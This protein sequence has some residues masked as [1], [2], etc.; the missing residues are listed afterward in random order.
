MVDYA[1]LLHN[2]DAVVP[3]AADKNLPCASRATLD[4]RA[5]VYFNPGLVAHGEV[6]YTASWR[7]DGRGWVPP[8]RVEFR[9]TAEI[10]VRYEPWVYVIPVV[11]AAAVILAIAAPAILPAAPVFAPVLL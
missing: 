8:A 10:E 3:V 2:Q 1:P 9:T 5:W 7:L 4:T 6:I 11:V